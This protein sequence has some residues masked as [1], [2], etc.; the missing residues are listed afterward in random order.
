MDIP[1]DVICVFSVVRHPGVALVSRDDAGM[2]A[3]A[4][5]CHV[6]KRLLCNGCRDDK[7]VHELGIGLFLRFGPFGFE[8]LT[9]LAGKPQQCGG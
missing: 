4:S 6:F 8:H 5:H 1:F 9:Q 7:A 3:G 2:T